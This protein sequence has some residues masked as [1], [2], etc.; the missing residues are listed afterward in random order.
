MFLNAPSWGLAFFC[1]V[2][3]DFRLNFFLFSDDANIFFSHNE[4]ILL[5]KSSDEEPLKLTSWCQV[6]KLSI[7]YSQFKSMVFNPRKTKVKP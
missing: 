6:N 3:R 7:N 2:S 4:V 5:E 1:D